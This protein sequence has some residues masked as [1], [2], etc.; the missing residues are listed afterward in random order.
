[1]IS[2][3]ELKQKFEILQK[4]LRAGLFDEV[5]EGAHILLNKRK[6]QV[7]FNII[8]LAYQSKGDYEKSVEIMEKAL[9]AN[10]ENPHFLNNIG[11]SY[12]KLDEFKKAEKF[13]LRG[14]E[15]EPKYIN[16]LNNL[17][18]LKRDLNFTEEAIEYY[19]KTIAINDKLVEP[20][21]NLSLN[22]ESL[23]KFE[24]A[25]KCLEKIFK[26]NP[27]FTDAD[28]VYSTLLK[29]SKDHQHF[30]QMKSKLDNENLNDIQKSHLHFGLGKYFEDIED[31]ETSFNYYSQ[32]NKI[33]KNFTKYDFKKD[34]IYFEKLKK[35]DYKKLN[36]NITNS[37]RDLIF[38][39]G[40]P[41]SGTS[42][43]EQILSSHDN[44]SGGGELT[45]LEKIAKKIISK[46]E[47]DEE[48][49]Q[50]EIIELILD[51]KN[52][53][54]IK[55]SNFDN[56]TTFFTDK[57]P[58]NFRYIGI[59]K[60]VFPKAK[61]INCDRDPL[62]VGWSNFKN[63]FSGSLFFSNNLTDIGKFYL[64][65]KEMMHHWMKAYPEIIYNIEYSKL[66]ENPKPEIEKLLKFCGLDWDEKCLNHHN[67]KRSIK[68]ASSTQARKPIYKTALM[69]SSRF[70]KYLDDLKKILN[71]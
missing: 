7:L 65:Y 5:I 30:I 58:L 63:F 17:G 1:M 48:P 28:R 51:C 67:N 10:S 38:I 34:Q 37:H 50:E 71:S 19:K 27:K 16:I 52:E 68:T 47:A 41:R 2:D 14:L 55:I 46:F 24:E 39:V 29:Y 25:K 36:I 23:G 20:L 70:D 54:L 69:A 26:L 6:H 12:Y 44:V 42:L 11:L 64:L 66:I 61:I 31:Y 60:Y 40:M 35:F 15:T 13:Y 32:G 57:A 3:I 8:S 43:V 33:I 21:F 53:Y 56:T 9:Q 4:K 18:N 45:F 49:T 22:Y 59:I 62:N